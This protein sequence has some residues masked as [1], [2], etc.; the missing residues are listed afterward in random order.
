MLLMLQLPIL[1][2][3]TIEVAFESAL[4]QYIQMNP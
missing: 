4:A 3:Q 2:F 1:L